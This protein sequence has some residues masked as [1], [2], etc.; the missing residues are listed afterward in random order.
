MSSAWLAR[1]P[2]AERDS[3]AALRLVAGV[4]LCIDG[5]WLW[6][7]GPR[8]DADVAVRARQVPGLERCTG[9]AGGP[10]VPAGRQLPSGRVPAEGWQ[11][12]ARELAPA[13][14]PV[15]FPGRLAARVTPIVVRGGGEQ[16]CDLLRCAW[17]D[18]SAW[19][20]TAPDHRLARLRFAMGDRGEV[21]VAGTPLPPVPGLR[22][23]RCGPL[24]LPAGWTCHPPLDAATAATVFATTPDDVVLAVV[25]EGAGDDPGWDVV[26]ATAWAV[27]SRPAVRLSGVADG[28]R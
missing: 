15:A 19:V 28:Q 22:H 4:E 9:T 5:P 14:P 26:P 6:L 25:D 17:A 10:A 13:A 1:L 27:A 16:P 8:W 12:L 23:W 24:A 7:R 21:L 3:A 2:L 18:F 11:P 20:E